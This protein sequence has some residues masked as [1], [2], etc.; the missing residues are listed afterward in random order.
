MAS[1]HN[2]RSSAAKQWFEQL[3]QKKKNDLVSCDV[4]AQSLSLWL[5][6]RLIDQWPFQPLMDKRGKAKDPAQYRPS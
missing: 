3:A 5:F 1:Q 4:H 2:P 6:W